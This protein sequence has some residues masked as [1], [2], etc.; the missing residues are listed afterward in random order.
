MKN[1]IADEQTKY[2]TTIYSIV[3]SETGDIL[4]LHL[5]YKEALEKVLELEKED[6]LSYPDK[7]IR[8][9]INY[10]KVNLSKGKLVEQLL[11]EQLE[12]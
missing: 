12:D 8:Y 2:M 7:Y 11:V 1:Y 5:N 3:I 9:S 10:H 6:R 4:S